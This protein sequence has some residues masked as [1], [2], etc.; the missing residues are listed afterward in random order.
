MSE[1]STVM[2]MSHSMLSPRKRSDGSAYLDVGSGEA[3]VLLHGVGLNADAWQP[4]IQELSKTHR[5]IAIDMLG[6]GE[7]DTAKGPATLD[8][9]VRQVTDLLTACGISAA[10]VIGHSMGGLIALGFALTHPE[11]TL[12]IGVL[13]S[14]YK[15]S[16][17]RRAAVIARAREIATTGTVGDIEDPLKRWFGLR[18]QQPAIAQ[19]VRAWLHSVN[20][21][22]YADAYGIFAASDEAFAGK[23]DQLTMPALFA[24]GS[25]DINSSPAMASAMANE[26]PRG[27]ALVLEGE[28]HMMSLT[29]P[30]AVNIALRELLRQP[31]SVIDPKD[32]RKAFGTF[33]TGVTVVTTREAS[34]AL[35]GFTANSFSSV[36]LDPPLLMVCISKFASSCQ[37]FS[38]SPHFAVN[39]L[40]EAQKTESGIFASKLADKF[41][42]VSYAE[43]ALGNP[44][45]PG[46][47]AWFD[48]AR[49]HVVDAGDH[50]ILIGRVIS[51]GHSDASPLG[52]ANG[53]YFTLGLEQSAVNA[54]A[55]T[56]RTEVGAILESD[57]KLLVFPG[58]NET[59]EL[60]QVG[61]SG[62]AGSASRL[63]ADLASRGIAAKLGFLF[64]VY[65]DSDNRT[66]CIFYRGECEGAGMGLLL[67]FDS[68]PLEK[69]RDNATRSMLSRYSAERLEGRYKIYSGNQLS[70]DVRDVGEAAG[71]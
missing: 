59:F 25:Q 1:A 42:E 58:A 31:T 30:T 32:L 18:G 4:Q 6:H 61:S 33:M 23:L 34:G 8:G 57:G 46:A 53:G 13:N 14:V 69:F 68:L 65:E 24:T 66:Q 47:A 39:I 67:D 3:I 40:S 19:D 20:P 7:S 28:R 21:Q 38:A 11:R 35:R 12:R 27:K 15:R 49:H 55:Q 16:A 60:P 70:G 51:Y 63:I 71:D 50:I 36:S 10:N 44:L 9:Y 45:L 17:E 64:A 37:I 54:A 62:D 26:A 52:Y 5:V 22:G 48:C 56:G 29:N 2:R 43:S 41:A